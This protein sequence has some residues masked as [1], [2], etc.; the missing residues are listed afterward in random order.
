[1]TGSAA[2]GATVGGAAPQRQSPTVAS[3]V[4]DG[5]VTAGGDFTVGGDFY[6]SYAQP[7]H[8]EFTSLKLDD[9]RPPYFPCPKRIN[10]MTQAIRSHRLLVLAGSS[11]IDKSD[12]ARH[13]AWFFG[14]QQAYAPGGPSA[15]LPVLE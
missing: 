7:D 8:E 3:V 11:G 2:P 10:T 4:G 12:L 9:Y 5:N 15:A 1:M 6:Y 13:V 14:D